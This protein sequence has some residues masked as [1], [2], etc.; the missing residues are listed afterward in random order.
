ML[1]RIW[2]I[3]DM[4]TGVLLLDTSDRLF[5][6]RRMLGK[7]AKLATAKYR[8]HGHFVTKPFMRYF[9][10]WTLL[11]RRH[12]IAVQLPSCITRMG[13][14]NFVMQIIF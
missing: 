9:Q 5:D 3:L 8:V 11:C 13:V 7:G 10:G 4:R 12:S 2:P 6:P 14:S 1:L